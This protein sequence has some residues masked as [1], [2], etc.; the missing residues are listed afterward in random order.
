MAERLVLHLF[1]EKSETILDFA[2]NLR[3]LTR[4][5][6]CTICHNICENE[7]CLYCKD[8]KRDATTLA[9]VED[10][11]DI[12]ALE[13]SGAFHGR[14]HVLGGMLDVSES[15]KG[16]F[17]LSSL[18]ERIQE[19]T[20]REIILAF[21]PTAEGDMTVLYLKQKLIP[22]GVK[23]TRLARGLSTGG[24][25]EYADEESLASAIENR[26]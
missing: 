12:I 9:V 26:K 2:E 15:S 11:L 5:N 20:I 10:A 1:K 23:V 7:V 4:L 3:A 18:L 25:I 6:S 17:T 13:R 14:Y 24:D 21:N 8:E 16:I 19:N 22:L